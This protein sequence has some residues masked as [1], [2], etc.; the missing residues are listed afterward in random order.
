[1]GGLLGL[2]VEVLAEVEGGEVCGKQKHAPTPTHPPTRTHSQV[3]PAPAPR[4]L[5]KQ[6][7][8]TPGGRSSAPGGVSAMPASRVNWR[9]NE[10]AVQSWP[11]SRG[12]HAQLRPMGEA[13]APLDMEVRTGLRGRL[14][15]GAAAL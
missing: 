8:W 7:T 2:S 5:N 13:D 6:S 10:A 11:R 14:R 1:V 3:W 12:P 9:S 15:E 4:V